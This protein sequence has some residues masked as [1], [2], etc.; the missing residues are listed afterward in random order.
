M[1]TTKKRCVEL[2]WKSISTA[3]REPHYRVVYRA[4]HQETRQLI[5]PPS[6]QES[7][8]SFYID[9]RRRSQLQN[10]Q[11]ADSARGLPRW[12]ETGKNHHSKKEELAKLCPPQFPRY[13]F[14]QRQLVAMIDV[15]IQLGGWR[16]VSLLLCNRKGYDS[17]SSLLTFHLRYKTH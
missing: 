14:V 8:K 16:C 13:H 3:R 7:G 6:G 15:V 5:C 10:V 4:W 2:R 1:E 12:L 17:G 11:T 9:G